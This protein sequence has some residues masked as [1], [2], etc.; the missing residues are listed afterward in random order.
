MITKFCAGLIIIFWLVMTAL[1]IRQEFFPSDDEA[2]PVSPQ[3]VL[4]RVFD[5][6]DPSTLKV[7]YEG[8]EA[9]SARFQVKSIEH[10]PSACTEHVE[11]GPSERSRYDVSFELYLRLRVLDNTE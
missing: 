1:L 4:K 6:D 11:H 5:A 10:K 7:Y 8:K 9:G 3:L 2:I